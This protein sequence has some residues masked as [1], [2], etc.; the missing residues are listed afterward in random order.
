MP[1]YPYKMNHHLSYPQLW[2]KQ[3]QQWRADRGFAALPAI[4][5]S[6]TVVFIVGCGHTGTTLLSAKLGNHSQ[7][8]VVETETSAFIPERGLVAAHR[9]ATSWLRA[10]EERGR[11]VLVEKTPKHVHCI[12][13]IRS[14]FPQA[15]FVVLTRNPLDTVA[16]LHKRHSKLQRSA[17]RW[18]IDSAP[19]SDLVANGALWVK[20]ED[21]TAQPELEFSRV[22]AFLGLEFEPA[23]LEAGDTV[24][25]HTSAHENMQLRRQQVREAIKPRRG[26][27]RNVLPL[28]QAREVAAI[29]Q[30]VAQALQYDPLAEVEHAA[31]LLEHQ[32]SR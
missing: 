20:Y 23:M 24:Y 15:Q 3:W 9:E 26:T 25:E 12:E 30:E 11:M 31:S 29:T 21:L 7:V 2:R 16:S 13:R 27:W 5:T 18:V 28:E 22:C 17:E 6:K 14:V 10:A 1:I 8:H 4:E 19:T 32:G